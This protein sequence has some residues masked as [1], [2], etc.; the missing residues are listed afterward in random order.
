MGSDEDS[1]N[2]QQKNSLFS[3]Q[4]QSPG[5]FSFG[6]TNQSPAQD[7]EVPQVS[8]VTQIFNSQ[9]VFESLSNE[10]LN[11]PYLRSHASSP[12]RQASKVGSQAFNSALF[13]D[14]A[15]A[16]QQHGACTTAN[17]PA[18]GQIQAR[19]EPKFFSNACKKFEANGPDSPKSQMSEGR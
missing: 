1:I 10:T 14:F 16:N 3:K 13:I 2:E 9:H 8:D 6:P 19:I 4:F 18:N 15:E 11:R 12:V 7:C 17:S 5:T